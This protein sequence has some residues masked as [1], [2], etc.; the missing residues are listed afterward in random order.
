MPTD[1]ELALRRVDLLH[2]DAGRP[3][4]RAV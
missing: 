2:E 4:L 1:A 3:A